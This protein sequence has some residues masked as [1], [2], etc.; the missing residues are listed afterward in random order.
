MKNP[1]L[2]VTT[3][4]WV[5]LFKVVSSAKKKDVEKEIRIVLKYMSF[6][7]QKHTQIFSEVNIQKS[8]ILSS[9]MSH[10]IVFILNNNGILKS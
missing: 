6:L 1:A 10:Y 7:F 8:I 9:D 3:G 5:L 2:R 4:M